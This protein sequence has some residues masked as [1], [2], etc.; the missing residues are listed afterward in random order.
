MKFQKGDKVICIETEGRKGN[1]WVKGL[2]FIIHSTT[3][4]S[5]REEDIIYWHKKSSYGIRGRALQ[6]M[7]TSWKEKYDQ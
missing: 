1:G 4:D 5:A 6:L 7:H 2:I 3:P